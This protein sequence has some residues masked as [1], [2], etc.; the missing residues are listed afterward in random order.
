M[1]GSNNI[2]V[3]KGVPDA[4]HFMGSD[5][6][7]LVIDGYTGIAYFWLQGAVR[8]IIGGTFLVTAAFSDGFSDGFVNGS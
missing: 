7:P 1:I 3:S 8:P 2:R 5:G 4:T 6:T